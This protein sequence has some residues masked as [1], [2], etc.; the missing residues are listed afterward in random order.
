MI[1]IASAA[2]ITGA[3]AAGNI[4][5]CVATNTALKVSRKIKDKKSK[6]NTDNNTESK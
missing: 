5:S 1:T 6:K 3:V 4:I 2:M